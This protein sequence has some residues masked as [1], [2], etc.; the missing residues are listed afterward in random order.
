MSKINGVKN[1]LKPHYHRLQRMFKFYRRIG[2][3]SKDFS[4]IS[5]NCTGGYVYQYYGI[6]YNTPTEGLYFTTSDY[7]KLMQIPEYY[8]KQKVHL[9]D[10]QKSSLYKEGRIINHPVGLIDDVEVYFLHYHDPEEALSKW[11]RR[12]SRINYNK[13]FFLL[14]E[15]E[16]M[17]QGH[18]Q[19][20]S[21][22]IEKKEYT[23]VCLT[24]NDYNVS[25]SKFIPN[26]PLD[27]DN[28]NASWKPEIIISSLDWKNILNS[29]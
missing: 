23:G 21:E 14:T 19:Q 28:G 3:Y 25:H 4:I 6:P 13:L 24:M 11:Y 27:E 16:L 9:I 5:N 1:A 26:V 17:K 10:P 29:L 7:I 12:A 15:T 20:F 22:T 2:L 18:V 8:F